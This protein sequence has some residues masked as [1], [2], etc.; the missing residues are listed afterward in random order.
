MS[1]IIITLLV[2]LASTLSPSSGEDEHR[3][4]KA[5]MEK[6]RFVPYPLPVDDNDDGGWYSGAL[7]TIEALCLII[8]IIIVVAEKSSCLVSSLHLSPHYYCM[9]AINSSSSNG[10]SQRIITSREGAAC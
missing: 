5:G 1:Y 7:Y 10:S 6:C 9:N 8:A 4:H 2:P 3:V